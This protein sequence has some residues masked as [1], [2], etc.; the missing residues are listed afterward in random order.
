VPRV[1]YKDAE[2]PRIVPHDV[3]VDHVI[4]HDVEIDIPHFATAP[5]AV[6]HSREEQKFTESEG[7]R[8]S[9]I[10]GRIVRK[11]SP[12]GFVLATDAG[13][14]SFFPVKL[15][16]SGRPTPNPG[17]RDNVESFLGDLGYCS[18]LPAG[19]Y[20][21]V[22]RHAGVETEIPQVPIGR[23]VARPSVVGKPTLA[24]LEILVRPAAVE[25]KR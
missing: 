21:C 12:N 7:W 2:V 17:V 6:P 16:A 9:T 24:P 5:T 20:H 19:A 10:R 11:E 15:D 8:S 25:A 18:P 22:V 3:T 4:P 23:G 1:S 14:L 13:E